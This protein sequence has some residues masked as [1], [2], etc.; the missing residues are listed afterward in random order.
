MAVI[1]RYRRH[2]IGNMM[3]KFLL[4]KIDEISKQQLTKGIE[5]NDVFL[6]TTDLQKPATSLYR[7]YDFKLVHTVPVYRLYR[8]MQFQVEFYH[9]SI[10]I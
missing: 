4:A 1:P 2:G 8:Q 10:N 3:M 5:I 6:Y 9:K 7:K